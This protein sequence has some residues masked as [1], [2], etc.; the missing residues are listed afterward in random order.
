M[1]AFYDVDSN[2]LIGFE[3]FVRGLSALNNKHRNTEKLRRIFKGYD[4]D[5]DGYVDRRDFLRMFRA[6][7][8]LSK[9]LVKDMVASMDDDMLEANQASN[10]LVGSQPI[11]AAFAGSIPPGTRRDGKGGAD[12]DGDE[13]SDTDVAAV[14]LPSG[15][16]RIS[17]DE[18]RADIERRRSES[19]AF[20]LPEVRRGGA[21]SRREAGEGDQTFEDWLAAGEDFNSASSAA[22]A[23]TMPALASADSTHSSASSF[24]SSPLPPTST[25]SAPN[26]GPSTVTA[27]TVGI[28]QRQE[29]AALAAQ[30]RRE[31]FTAESP[32]M[33]ENGDEGVG[34]MEMGDQDVGSEVLYQ[35]TQQGL[36]ELLDLL[37]AAKEEM[38]IEAMN[39]REAVVTGESAGESTEAPKGESSVDV[40]GGE[41]KEGEGETADA[42]KKQVEKKEMAKE[43]KEISEQE[44][45]KEEIKVRGGEGRL[46]F[47]EFE[48]IMK[49]KHGRDLVFVS[50]WI[51]MASF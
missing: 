22:V 31:F 4:L 29:A 9:D 16:D 51:D 23:A 49:G 21:I 48:E 39:E 38:A 19:A 28:D 35:I 12:W 43:E 44:R 17:R 33:S 5:D 7:Y 42:E 3:E 18:I 25:T 15:N 11:S 1:F 2:G 34:G 45:V 37:F 50:T 46:D 36:N 26:A 14:I 40:E 20:T 10:V 8:A 32:T 47:K 27:E 41:K 6:F 30:R 24:V 13:D